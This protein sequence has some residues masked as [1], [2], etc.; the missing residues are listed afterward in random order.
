MERNR[1]WKLDWNGLDVAVQ[2]TITVN[3]RWHH[4]KGFS[5]PA[6][7]HFPLDTISQLKRYRAEVAVSWE[8]GTRTMLAALYRWLYGSS[9]LLVWA[10]FSESTDH[11]RG[12]LRLLVR[13]VLHHAVDGFLVTGESG[14]RYLRSL[15]VPDRKIHK[16]FYT[17]EVS[18]FVRLRVPLIDRTRRLLYVGQLIERKGLLQF[19]DTL[20]CW[21]K[22][23]A[24]HSVTLTLAGE[25]P[26]RLALE[27]HRLPP[28][29]KLFFRGNVAY[30]DL[31]G[32]YAEADTFVFPT[33]ADTWG[34]VVNEAMASGL[35]VLGSVY[36]QAVSELVRDGFS[37]WTFRP[38]MPAEMSTALDTCLS[39]P[40]EILQR[41]GEQARDTARR[42]TPEYVSNLV[43][44][45]IHSAAADISSRK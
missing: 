25:G 44:E 34:V 16:I 11:G 22:Q 6:Y 45:S 4:P 26:L 1:S 38:D 33:L 31:P 39:V 13:R 32:V 2:K 9:K 40:P 7:I 37:G 14:A 35:P 5:E 23:H 41:M 43:A 10:E 15:G 20:A 21:G 18:R 42:L 28:N 8:M 36:G 30:D 27:H 17:T 3:R 19:L 29:I 12:S 24:E